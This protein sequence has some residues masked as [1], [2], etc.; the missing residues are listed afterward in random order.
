MLKP[1]LTIHEVSAAIGV[2]RATIYR[3]IEAGRMSV[4]KIGRRTVIRA[5]DL[6]KFIDALP[7]AETR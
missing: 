1:L 2:S 3:Q 5:E 4:R 7:G 6:Q